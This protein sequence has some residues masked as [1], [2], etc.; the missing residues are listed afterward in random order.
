MSF[1]EFKQLPGKSWDEEYNYPSIDRS[2]RNMM[3]DIVVV[4][5][6][7]SHKK[8]KLW[9]RRVFDYPKCCFRLKTEKI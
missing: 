5:K 9:K 1:D 8:N 3:E 4:M 7:K 6:S 2:K